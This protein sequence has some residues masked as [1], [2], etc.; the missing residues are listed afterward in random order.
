[1]KKLI[2]IMLALLLSSMVFAESVEEEMAK[3]QKELGTLR[4]ALSNPETQALLEA[5]GVDY[6]IKGDTITFTEDGETISITSS[7]D[8]IIIESSDGE[9]GE[10]SFGGDWPENEF[11][12][13]LPR[14][15]MRLAMAAVAEG[16]FTVVF[17]DA[18]IDKLKDYVKDLK[19]HGFDD[20]DTEEE[21][22]MF[23]MSMYTFI[24][25]NKKGYKVEIT[26][27]MGVNSMIVA[28]DND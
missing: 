2:F 13:L 18:T 27:A 21:I 12:K 23:G 25:E 24:A 5:E 17:T 16:K 10:F 7:G 9:S 1:M 8:T 15:K 6:D 20:V 14:P 19:R 11:T 22:A 3:L 26:S 28:K 4:E